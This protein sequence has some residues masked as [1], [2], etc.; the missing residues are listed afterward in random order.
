MKRLCLC[1]RNYRQGPWDAS[2]KSFS[3]RRCHH[4][5]GRTR[6]RPV[7]TQSQLAASSGIQSAD[8]SAK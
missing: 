1:E 3:S 6:S 2:T 5:N 4:H 8:D 7:Y